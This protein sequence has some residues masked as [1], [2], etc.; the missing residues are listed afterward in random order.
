[1]RAH[2]LARQLLKLP[3]L[4]VVFPQ[5]D[6]PMGN[7]IMLTV[8]EAP[9]IVVD[10][11]LVEPHEQPPAEVTTPSVGEL[12]VGSYHHVAE[13]FPPGDAG[14]TSIPQRCFLCNEPAY[15]L[16]CAKCSAMLD[17][18]PKWPAGEFAAL[19]AATRQRFLEDNRDV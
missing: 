12:G 1:M 17:R 9:A 11:E 10:A 14:T 7:Y 15:G 6:E 3:D 19:E 8:D 2:E 18:I 13:Q 5:E 16:A 4:P